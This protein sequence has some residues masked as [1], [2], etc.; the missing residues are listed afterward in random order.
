MPKRK[1]TFEECLQRMR[2]PEQTARAKRM[3]ELEARLR[4]LRMP[5]Q[6]EDAIIE[7]NIRLAQEGGR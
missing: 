6:D 4:R 3:A 1:R 5:V 2:R 7:D